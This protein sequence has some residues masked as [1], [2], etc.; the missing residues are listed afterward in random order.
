MSGPMVEV[1]DMSLKL[2]QA[3]AGLKR[4][5]RMPGGG[6]RHDPKKPKLWDTNAYEP[7]TCGTCVAEDTLRTIK[8]SL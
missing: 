2:S 6:P 4:I 3:L 7:C 8:E 1:A 5:A